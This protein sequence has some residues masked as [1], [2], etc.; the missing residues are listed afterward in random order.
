VTEVAADGLSKSYGS[1]KAIDDVSFAVRG[2]RVCALA[3]PNGAGKSTLIGMLL[4]LIR[5]E[6]GSARFD[7]CR[8]ADLEHPAGTVG[9]VV[10]SAGVHP[11]RSAREHLRV[12]ATAARVP[13]ARVDEL[14]DMTGLAGAADRAA[15]TFS[16]GMLQRLRLACALLG[17]PRVLILDEPANG[18]DPEGRRWLRD[19]LAAFARAGGT[20]LVATHDLGEAELLADDVMIL[21]RGRVV[22]H[23]AIAE[24]TTADVVEVTTAQATQLAAA[25][26]RR[27]HGATVRGGVVTIAGMA[28]AAVGGLLIEHA[29]VVLAMSAR[30]RSLEDAFL[31]MTA[32]QG[33]R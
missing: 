27:G 22:A 28:P 13:R 33:P 3:G 8:Y 31:A 17:P 5:P 30:R 15:G 9:A 2:G 16:L 20:V 26:A 23:G 7:G 4:G 29:I 12:C 10:D 18:L 14:L 6:R 32:E 24:L 1:L 21:A 25:V 19:L 11:A